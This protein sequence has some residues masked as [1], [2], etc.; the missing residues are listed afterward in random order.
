M[1]TGG[2]IVAVASPDGKVPRTTITVCG[3]QSPAPRWPATRMI[4]EYEANARLIAHAPLLHQIV[5]D[6]WELQKLQLFRHPA[7]YSLAQQAKDAIKA[8]KG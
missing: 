8:V 1:Q 7:F 4:R 5:S 6:V 2:D 3:T